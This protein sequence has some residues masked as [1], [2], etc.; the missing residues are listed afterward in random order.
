MTGRSPAES[1]PGEDCT[2]ADDMRLVVTGAAGRMGRMLIKTISETPGTAL[3][4]ALEREGSSAIGGKD[5]GLGL[6]AGV[7]RGGCDDFDRSARAAIL[8]ADGILDFLERLRRASISPRSP[9][10]RAS[11]IMSSAPLAF[12]RGRSATHRRGGAPRR[13]RTLRQYEPW[14]Q[15]ARQGA[16]YAPRRA[17][18]SMK[19]SISKPSKCTIA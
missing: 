5:A 10:R 11:S 18:R 4:G 7:R 14:R 16:S 13:D 6:L 12:G 15:S 3:S 1:A 2:M 8:T 17:K 9:R 19:T